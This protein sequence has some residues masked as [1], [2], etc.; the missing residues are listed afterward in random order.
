MRENVKDFISEV[1][2]LIGVEG[3]VVELG[4]LQVEGQVG[5]AD[6][7]PLF[8]ERKFIGC[9]L[10]TG[11]GVDVRCNCNQ[12]PFEDESV[13][14][15]TMVDTL[16][17]VENFRDA[18]KEARRVL[19][20]NGILIASSVMDFPIHEHPDDYWRFTPAGFELLLGDFQ[21]RLVFF[22]GRSVMPHTVLGIGFKTA[23]TQESKLEL[24]RAISERFDGAIKV[25]T[26]DESLSEKIRP[27]YED[28][29]AEAKTRF[30]SDKYGA[31]IELDNFNPLSTHHQI[32]TR[33][34]TNSRVLEFGCASGHMS[35]VLKEDLNC[36]VTGVERNEK[37]AR[38]AKQ[39]CER[40]VIGDIETLDYEK[41]FPERFDVVLF[42]DV[43]EH[44]KEPDRILRTVRNMLT[45]DGFVLASI[46][47]IAHAS[48]TLPLLEGEFDYQS[49]G[50]LDKT[51]LRFYTK[52]SVEELFE[53][54]GYYIDSFLRI[55]VDPKFSHYSLDESTYPQEILDYIRQNPEWDT[56][57]FVIK[58][59]PSGNANAM[60]RLYEKLEE[61]RSALH[62][63][64]RTNL[65]ELEQQKEEN[66]ILAKDIEGLRGLLWHELERFVALNEDLHE[67]ARALQA[68]REREKKHVEETIALLEK[69]LREK[70]EVIN[71]IMSK[72]PMRVYTKIK[73][74]FS[75]E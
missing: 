4:S 58:A 64:R 65:A 42:S 29:H 48:V 32:L 33:V 27:I 25:F 9:D 49:L 12:L 24:I 11:V 60:K 34:R 73:H 66:R 3:S 1:T 46:P 56:Q 41:E 74:I 19:R 71:N 26:K 59:Y 51:H 61:A 2:R 18:A 53:A 22:Q 72:L 8:G 44:L 21:D 23:R 30:A 35:K 69:E 7:R 70:E 54:C 37:S 63:K 62:D 36:R 52:S 20:A 75:K 31:Y 67:H 14:C 45:P 50:I 17:H 13:G 40:V 6:L 55:K 68:L 28:V 47:N 43:L 38:Q 10:R 57:H 5:F 15:V 39:Y 16:E